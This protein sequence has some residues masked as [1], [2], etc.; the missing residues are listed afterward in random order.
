MNDR[1]GR[2][3]RGAASHVRDASGRDSEGCAT[4][5]STQRDVATW[6]SPA[7]AAILS[8]RSLVWLPGMTWRSGFSG[9]GGMFWARVARSALRYCSRVTWRTEGE[10]QGHSTPPA[11]EHLNRGLGGVT[12]T[13]QDEQKVTT[14]S[15]LRTVT[16]TKQSVSRISE[17]SRCP[18]PET[19]ADCGVRGASGEP[20]PCFCR[21]SS[22]F[23]LTEVSDS[24]GLYSRSTQTVPR[25]SSPWGPQQSPY[26]DELQVGKGPHS[27]VRTVRRRAGAVGGFRL[28]EG[29]QRG[30]WGLVN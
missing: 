15:W 22:L 13:R 6:C 9:D 7:A 17:S 12:V 3:E 2:K 29:L 18:D 1:M 8:P 26:L 21:A 24:S 14:A 23:A 4:S 10:A 19:G 30:H 5:G 20:R 16:R 25:G 11:H 28:Q 27:V